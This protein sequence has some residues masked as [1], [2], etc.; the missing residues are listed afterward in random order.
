MSRY[1]TGALPPKPVPL[2]DFAHYILEPLPPPPTAVEAPSLHWPMAGNDTYGDCTIA[3]ALHADQATAALVNVP[4]QYA[5]DNTVANTYFEL[6]GGADTGLPLTDVLRAWATEGLFGEQL[7]AF[8]PLYLPHTQTT[9]Q[10]VALAGVTYDAVALP[11]VAQQQH[12]EH[13]DWDLT[14]TTADEDIEG[15]HC[16][17]KVGYNPR[18]PVFVTWGSLQQA[19][20]RW[21]AKYG[22]ESYALV[23]AEVKKR[24]GL[25]GVDLASLERD[26]QALGR[27]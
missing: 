17:V 14:G 8:A 5:G 2:G 24:G 11:Q 7:V 23:T 12:L 16:I 20:W 19:T 1:C 4:W 25:R 13:K 3:G 9:K 18:G 27:A 21:W 22:T 6:T 26:V 15:G 10:A